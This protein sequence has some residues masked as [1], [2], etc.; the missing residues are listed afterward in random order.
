MSEKRKDNKNRNLLKGEQ[1]KKYSNICR[2]FECREHKTVSAIAILAFAK[3][4]NS[5]LLLVGFVLTNKTCDAID[6]KTRS[7]ADDKLGDQ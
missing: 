4:F 5:G 3:L 6:G 7:N 2:V 1:Q